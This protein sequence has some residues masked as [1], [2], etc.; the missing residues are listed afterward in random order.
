[1]SPGTRSNADGAQ[2]PAM[3]LIHGG[4]FTIGACSEPL[5]Y[6]GT[7]TSRN[8]VVVTTNYRRGTTN[9]IAESFTPLQ[10]PRELV[11][12]EADNFG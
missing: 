2:C 6:G 5:Y 10:A 12:L 8:V 3:V 1:M 7:L 4:G 9:V 11:A